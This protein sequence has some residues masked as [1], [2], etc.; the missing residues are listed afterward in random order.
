M[1]SYLGESEDK[2]PGAYGLAKTL[3]ENEGDQVIIRHNGITIVAEDASIQETG[4]SGRSNLALK[5]YQIVNG[6]QSSSVLFNHRDQLGDVAIPIKVV[7]TKDERI[8]NGVILGANTQTNVDAYDMLGA[9]LEIRQLQQHF[10]SLS[11]DDPIKLWLRRR[12][13]ERMFIRRY[14]PER[15]VTPRQL[16]DCFAATVEGVPHRVHASPKDFLN[17][18]Q[19]L[20][21]TIFA[22][23]HDPSVYMAMGW[24]V[25]AGRYWAVRKKYQWERYSLGTMRPLQEVAGYFRDGTSFS[26]LFGSWSIPSRI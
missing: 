26:T 23:D 16:L 22:E 9:R 11:A 10:Q 3:D 8:R 15:M 1:R 2:N 7:I 17:E 25:I 21:T 13:G 5:G 12:R 6:A 20:G 24:L 18:Q 19:F 4:D 14:D